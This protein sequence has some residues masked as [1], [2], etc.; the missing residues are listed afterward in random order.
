MADEQTIEQ[1]ESE[2]YLRDQVS[3][4]KLSELLSDAVSKPMHRI[5]RRVERSCW[6][7][8]VASRVLDC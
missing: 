7:E 1:H 2:R 4:I 6:L 5:K 3:A 8:S